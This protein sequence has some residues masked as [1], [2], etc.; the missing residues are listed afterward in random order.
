MCN[1]MPRVRRGRCPG[2]RFDLPP[3]RLSGA[4]APERCE[5]LGCAVPHADS[6]R[7]AA[8]LAEERRRDP[9]S[10]VKERTLPTSA[11][12]PGRGS[13]SPK[14][15][16]PAGRTSVLHTPLNAWCV[17]PTTHADRSIPGRQALWLFR[18]RNRLL[19]GGD[20][21]VAKWRELRERALGGALVYSDVQTPCPRVLTCVE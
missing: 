21:T 3:S 4:A 11:V 15:T 1:P 7:V 10:V 19:R 5:G 13:R 14:A 8:Y 12:T 18:S 6:A 17:L 20:S 9:H 2:G 16:G